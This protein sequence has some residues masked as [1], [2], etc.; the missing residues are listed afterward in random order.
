MKAGLVQINENVRTKDTKPKQ[1]GQPLTQLD[2]LRIQTEKIQKEQRE[3]KAMCL[4]KF[5]TDLPQYNT[6]VEAAQANIDQVKADIEQTEQ[7]LIAK[8]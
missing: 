8:S 4:A 1:A 6:D 2:L 5:L 7:D 3:F